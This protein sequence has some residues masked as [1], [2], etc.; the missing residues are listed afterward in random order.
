[1]KKLKGTSESNISKTFLKLCVKNTSACN[2]QEKII[3]TKKSFM[4]SLKSVVYYTVKA[5]LSLDQMHLK[6]SKSFCE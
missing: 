2:K 1:V 6:S 5:Q 3:E 4:L